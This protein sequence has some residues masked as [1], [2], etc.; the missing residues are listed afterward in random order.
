MQKLKCE[1]WALSHTGQ[2]E[3]TDKDSWSP[4]LPYPAS[5]NIPFDVKIKDVKIEGKSREMR[6]SLEGHDLWS[7]SQTFVRKQLQ[8]CED[9]NSS[10]GSFWIG[11]NLD[12]GP[13]SVGGDARPPI[14]AW[15]HILSFSDLN[16]TPHILPTTLQW[17]CGEGVASAFLSFSERRRGGGGSY[18]AVRWRL[19][20]A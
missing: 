9:L 11:A 20:A 16:K 7:Q 4:S 3:P 14:Q 12:L 15:S 2:W 8:N 19:G 13:K 18:Q 10:A 17:G 1:H 5:R 6:R